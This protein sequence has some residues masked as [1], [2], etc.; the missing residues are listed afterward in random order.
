[1]EQELSERKSTSLPARAYLGRQMYFVTICCS[2]KR[3]LLADRMLCKALVELLASEARATRFSILAYCFMPD[4]VHLLAEGLDAA[5]DCRHFLKR[6]KIKSS[7]SFAREHGGSL[8]QTRY[9]DH[10]LRPREPVEDFAWYIWLN[11]VRRG[12]VKRPEE[13]AF[14]G[15][16]SGIRMPTEWS[17]LDWRPH[18]K[19][20]P[21]SG[22]CG[23][24]QKAVPT[25]SN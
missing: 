4:H 22:V 15:S 17:K 9:F 5:S 8:W 1:M 14:S 23:R 10:I 11:P 7:R 24:P 19:A 12:L 18:W 25:V 2:Q 3:A 20:L 21:S 6:F 16:L 13:Y